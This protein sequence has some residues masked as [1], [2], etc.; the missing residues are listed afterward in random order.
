MRARGSSPRMRGAPGER[1]RGAGG[2][3]IIPADAGSTMP[4]HAS[5]PLCW[6]HP[7]GCGE[8]PLVQNVRVGQIGSSPRMRGAPQ[9]APDDRLGR[10]IIPA[11]AGSTS[12]YYLRANTYEDHPRGCG[13]HPMR[14]I[15]FA[16]G[17]GSSPRM[18]GAHSAASLIMSVSGIIPADAGSTKFLRQLNF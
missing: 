16:G 11:D 3:R 15:A 1:G 7:R 8:H 10:G 9:T 5:S 13:E 17:G 4:I 2:Q 6:D 12:Q 18:R 14:V